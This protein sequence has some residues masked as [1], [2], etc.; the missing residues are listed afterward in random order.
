MY[1]IKC[2]SVREV[3]DRGRER[4]REISNYI[5]QICIVNKWLPVLQGHPRR[6]VCERAR[7]SR[8]TSHCEIRLIRVRFKGEHNIS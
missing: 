4:E 1:I 5:I 3:I 7:A 8:R 2:A 6:I